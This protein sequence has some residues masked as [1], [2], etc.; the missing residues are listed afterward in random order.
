MKV[1]ET[2]RSIQYR[3][4]G[5]NVVKMAIV[6]SSAQASPKEPGVSPRR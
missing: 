4:N 1:A 2:E 3:A 6:T 5:T